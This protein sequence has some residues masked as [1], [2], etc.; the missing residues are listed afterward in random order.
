MKEIE[1]LKAIGVKRFELSMIEKDAWNE[2]APLL[3]VIN[4]AGCFIDSDMEIFNTG[5][6]D[7]SI[8]EKASNAARKIKEVVNEGK[9]AHDEYF[10][11]A[12]IIW[13]ILKRKAASNSVPPFVLEIYKSRYERMVATNGDLIIIFI[14]FN[15]LIEACR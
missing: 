6:L 3:P 1:E 2:L 8:I 12:G 14:D 13:D 11:K 5:S 10:R 7:I 4:A 9:E 15:D